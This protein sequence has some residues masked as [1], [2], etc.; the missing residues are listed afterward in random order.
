MNAPFVSILTTNA[1]P[2]HVF[3]RFAVSVLRINKEP[4]LP[5]KQTLTRF[6]LNQ[7]Q[8]DKSVFL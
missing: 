6:A 3:T 1:K 7:D 5:T 2:Y 4:A 8:P